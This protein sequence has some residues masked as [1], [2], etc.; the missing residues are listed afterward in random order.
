MNL[1]AV[2][3]IVK[4]MRELLDHPKFFKLAMWLSG[5][6]LLETLIVKIADILRAMAELLR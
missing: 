1:E 2:C 4:L 6:I 3:L 5:W